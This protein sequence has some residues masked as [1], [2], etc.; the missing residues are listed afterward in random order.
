MLLRRA[1]R[2]RRW[3][4]FRMHFQLLMANEIPGEYDYLMITCG[5]VSLADRIANPQAAVDRAY[6]TADQS[7]RC[8]VIGNASPGRN[9]TP[10]TGPTPPPPP[11]SNPPPFATSPMHRIAPP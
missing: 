2:R 11:T 8:T 4:L 9:S 7:R 3:N 10:Q 6:G 1:D 5:P